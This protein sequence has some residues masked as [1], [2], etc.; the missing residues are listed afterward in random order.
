VSRDYLSPSVAQAWK[1]RLPLPIHP[2]LQ[3]CPI[4]TNAGSLHILLYT[5]RDVNMQDRGPQLAGIC[6]ALLAMSIAAVSVR[7][8]VRAFLTKSFGYDDWLIVATLVWSQCTRIALKSLTGGLGLV[9]PFL[10]GRR[11]RSALWHR[12]AHGR[13]LRPRHFNGYGGEFYINDTILF[14]VFGPE[15]S[16]CGSCVKSSTASP[17]P[18]PNSLLAQCCFA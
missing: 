14:G 18:S 13:S 10:P 1:A 11:D 15:S 12:T 5:S 17:P 8:Y 7:C 3:W 16:R 4:P 6:G 9:L 2:F